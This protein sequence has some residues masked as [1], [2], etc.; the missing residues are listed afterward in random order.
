[1]AFHWSLRDSN[2]NLPNILADLN[3]AVI[4]M[5]SILPLISSAL[6]QSPFQDSS[7]YSSLILHCCGLDGLNSSSDFQFSLFLFQAF[8]DC[9]KCT[10]YNWYCYLLH[11]PQS[12]HLWQD[13]NTGL[14]FCFP[15]FF[16]PLWSTWSTKIH[17]LFFSS[18]WLIQGPARI[19]WS[20]LY[21]KVP[22][23]FMHFILENR[24]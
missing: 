17:Q 18:C 16:F 20:V 10:N 14:S 22:E 5:V 19:G 1:M 13:Q 23:N 4:W 8:G 7:K 9:S 15:F 11:V 6:P 12:Y 21:H 24:F 2:F 3:S